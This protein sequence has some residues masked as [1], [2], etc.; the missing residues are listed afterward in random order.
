MTRSVRSLGARISLINFAIV[1]V[2]FSAFVLAIVQALSALVEKQANDDLIERTK[3]V[4][5]LLEASERDLRQRAAGLSKI[6]QASL[7]GTFQLDETPVDINGKPAPSLKLDGRLLDM[8]FSVVDRF[9]AQTGAVATV[10]AKTGDDFIRVTTSLKDGHGQRVMGTLLDRVHPG[11]NAARSGSGYVGLATLFGRN[12]MTH[13]DPIKDS[14]GRII[15]L[16][17]VGLDFTDY[18]LEMKSTIRDMKIGKTGYFYILDAREGA[19]YGNMVVHP[20]GEGK[21]FLEAK[22]ASGAFVIKDILQR[23]T[24][25]IR[26][27]WI[28]KELGEM[29]PREKVVAF[30]MLK[31]W[32]WIL[33]GGTYVDEYA[34][35]VR[36]LRNLYAVLGAVVVVFAAAMTYVLIR[37]MVIRPLA[38]VSRAADQVSKGDLTVRLHAHRADEIGR[39]VESMNQI[40]IGLTSVVHTVRLG[41]EGVA[42]ASAE[43]A[44]GNNDLSARTEQQAGALE[45]TASSMEQLGAQV[46]HNADSA[47]Q[48]NQLAAGASAIAVEG[49]AVVDRVVDTMKAINDASRKIADIIGV[50]DGIAFQTNILA[51]NAAVEAAR[52]GEQGRGF[53]VVASEVRSLAGRSAEA[54]KEIKR[55]INDSV[56]RVDQGSALVDEAGATM[57]KVVESIQR[58][59]VLVGEISSASSEQATGVAQVGMAVAQMDQATQQNAALVEQM[60]AAASSLKAQAGDL[61]GTVAV[62][63]IEAPSRGVLGASISS[64]SLNDQGQPPGPAKVASRPSVAMAPNA[65]RSD[66]K[67]SPAA[68]G[69][70]SGAIHLEGAEAWESF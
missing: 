15:G 9:T 70:A 30:A 48:A 50:I 59:T 6:F 5:A 14:G 39:L 18:M 8:D 28:N 42:T 3:V 37:R 57:G 62:F 54:A 38:E 68:E 1:A 12:Y 36:A 26:Y 69:R 44:Q 21:S 25:V 2:L 53:A 17:F 45:E 16:L 11:Y 10:F 49:G 32:D 33:A 63:K 43:I 58:V 56:E 52:A 24:G 27:P 61:V 66:R 40:G 4:G 55:L 64:A 46:K 22:D 23:K 13:Y 7:S 34:V 35:E 47:K 20:T 19:N 60:A 51:L 31:G 67:A 65:S 41:A 29:Q